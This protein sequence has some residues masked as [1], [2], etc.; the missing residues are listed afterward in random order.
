MFAYCLNNPVRYK[1]TQGYIV[2]DCYDT[3]GEMFSSDE[4]DER[5]GGGGGNSFDAQQA[6]L[7]G[8]YV[9]GYNY[10]GANYNLLSNHISTGRSQPRNLEEQ[11][12]MK[13]A[14]TNPQEGTVI[15]EALND[16]RLAGYKKYARHYPTSKGGIEVHYVGNSETNTF[17]DFKFK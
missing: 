8:N 10:G 4:L 6:I 7:D 11:I 15:K 12:A 16:P 13:A 3:D 9:G 17:G 14:R 2:T 1:D 5:G